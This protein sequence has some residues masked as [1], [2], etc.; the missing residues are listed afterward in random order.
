MS[1]KEVALTVRCAKQPSKNFH[2]IFK[3]DADKGSTF[4]QRGSNLEWVEQIEQP[5][6][7]DISSNWL[8]DVDLTPLSSCENLEYLSLANNSLETLDLS[9]LESCKRLRTLDLSHNYLKDIDLSPLSGCT[10]LRYLYLQENM[11]KK[12]NVAALF[13]LDNL[14]IAVIQLTTRATRPKVVIDSPMSSSP[15]NLNDVVY[16]YL[17]ERKAGFIPEWLYNKDSEIEYE[18]RTYRELVKEF[19][20][21]GVKKHLTAISK[22]LRIGDDFQTQQILFTA[23]GIPELACY[24]GSLR[25]LI[26]LLPTN[27]SYDEGIISLQSKM[28]NTLE[29][30]LEQGRSTLYFDVDALSTTRGSVLIPLILQRRDLEME[31]V[32]L[33]DHKGRIDLLPLWVTSYGSKI[34]KALN[35]GRWVTS[36]R[37]PDIEKAL[38]KINHEVAIE[39]VLYDEGNE[40]DGL[41]STG[42]VLLSHVRSTLS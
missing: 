24:D 14:T 28:V 18:P 25:D 38:T 20:W 36:I 33:F 26:K 40:K 19:G 10:S 32:T 5:V 37:L 4:E 41:Y 7:I 27:G 1:K 6:R 34:L 13:Q 12:V 29:E 42:K 31:D 22:S 2:F 15:P 16:A 9:P 3:T 39:K 30:Q 21:D 35:L 17:I 11:F 8:T 23:L